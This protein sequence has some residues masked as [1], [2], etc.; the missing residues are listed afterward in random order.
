[1]TRRRR[2][3]PVPRGHQGQPAASLAPLTRHGA[4]GKPIAVVKSGRT[5]PP[6]RTARSHTGALLGQRRRVRRLLR[7]GRHRPL[8]DAG[9]AVRDTQ[10]LPRGWTTGRT[11]A[12]VMGASGGDMAMTADVSRHLALEFPP[13]AADA[14]AAGRHRRRAR[15][16]RESVRHAHLSLVPACAVAPA[17]RRSVSQR[18]G[19]RGPDA[20]LPTGSER[21]RLRLHRGDRAVR[22]GAAGRREPRRQSFHRCP[23]PPVAACENCVSRTA[24]CR[25]RA[26]A[27]RSRRC[28]SRARSANA[29]PAAQATLRSRDRP[30][31]GASCDRRTRGQE[32]HWR[33][34]GL[35]LPR[36]QLVPSAT[37][38]GPR[39][40][41]AFRW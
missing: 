30:G 22:R 41:S 31:P 11:R 14:A 23:N 29:G 17:V 35:L 3:R 8:R 19:R 10:D 24:S 12:V 5:E 28:I 39:P 7:A 6:R 34:F 27:K 2:L 40:R 20:R 9:D 38:P 13:F 37:G 16:G 33:D 15:D 32:R 18:R 36:S 26:S 4:H 25:C 21:R 1:M